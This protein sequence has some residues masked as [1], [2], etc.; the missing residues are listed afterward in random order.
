MD[1]IE[2]CI[3]WD[4]HY[5]EPAIGNADIWLG[6]ISQNSARMLNEQH[7]G[8]LLE[9]YIDPIHLVSI[10]NNNGITPGKHLI[11]NVLPDM[12]HMRSGD[13]GEIIA[14]SILQ[15]WRDKPRFPAFRWRNRSHKNDSVQGVDLLG[16][17]YQNG[18]QNPDTGDTLVLCEVKTRSASVSENIVC[19]AYNDS[20][21]HYISRLTTSLFFIQ[22]LL[23]QQGKIDEA[24]IFARFSRPH[25]IQYQ[26]R[27][28][29]FVVHE[30]KT[31]DENFMNTLSDD[32]P[33]D[34]AM[35][36]VVVRI[37]RLSSLIDDIY[38]AAVRIADH[39]ANLDQ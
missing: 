22:Q 10:A 14:R 2:R 1:Y 13:F 19:D 30:S 35:E 8:V 9:C 31:W 17:I 33:P 11:D 24:E 28:V 25:P 5:Q 20:K 36:V 38:N 15:G 12:P 39:N 18:N 4:K 29:S 34:D 6:S 37:E 7:G 26:R 16:Y 21:K 3:I 27:L 23:H 32:D